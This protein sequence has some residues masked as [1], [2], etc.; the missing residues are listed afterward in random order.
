MSTATSAATS[1]T[2]AARYQIAVLTDEPSFVESLASALSAHATVR[3]L[4]LNSAQPLVFG[5]G[6]ERAPNTL[7]VNRVSARAGGWAR[8]AADYVSVA[9]QRCGGWVNGRRCQA[10]AASKLAQSQ[11]VFEAGLSQPVSYFLYRDDASSLAFVVP[12]HGRWLLKPSVGA[13]GSQIRALDNKSTVPS[14]D[15]AF[16]ADGIALVQERIAPP[17]RLVHRA[18]LL[19]GQL[20]YIV[21]TPLADND[22]DYCVNEVRPG[23]TITA[24][25]DDAAFRDGLRRLSELCDMQIGAVEYL[26]DAQGRKQIIDI[27]PVSSYSPLCKQ[28]LGFDP[29]AKQVA[30]ILAVF[31]DLV[32]GTHHQEP[33][34]RRASA[35]QQSSTAAA[36]TA[37]T[38]TTN[39]ATTNTTTTTTT[40]TIVASPAKNDARQTPNQSNGTPS[41]SPNKQQQV[42]SSPKQ[43]N[44]N[45][46]NHNTANTTTNNN[47]QVTTIN[48]TINNKNQPA[49][50]SP[51]PISTPTRASTSE[52]PNSNAASPAVQQRSE[53]DAAAM[54]I[55]TCPVKG[56][57]RGP[58]K[59]GCPAKMGARCQKCQSAMHKTSECLSVAC[60]ACG[61]FLHSAGSPKCKSTPKP[62]QAN[63]QSPAKTP[64][65]P[66]S[67]TPTAVASKPATPAATTTPSSSSSSNNKQ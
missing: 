33:A 35:A 38:V 26:I 48:T 21:S 37:T 53:E 30:S 49:S 54:A 9:S 14:D 39:N 24:T 50:P 7:L 47:K 27:N 36:A 65:T 63:A 16:A 23:Q 13:Y 57:S 20:L 41:K 60:T 59:M 45:T 56:D 31:N 4:A 61:S 44:N 1:S 34:G 5:S 8:K 12:E 25:C 51:S 3:V 43:N 15:A 55:C 2:A 17:D 10:V 11:A 52:K 19:D 58:H 62:Q 28:K 67:T 22:F 32:A 40:N 64:S 42:S 66:K 18:E 29:L 6:G 46:T